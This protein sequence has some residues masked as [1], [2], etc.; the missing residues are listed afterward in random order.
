MNVHT[1]FLIRKGTSV[2]VAKDISSPPLALFRHVMKHDLTIPYPTDDEAEG[3][4]VIALS[5]DAMDIPEPKR[6]M[7]KMFMLTSAPGP[8]E[9]ASLLELLQLGFD[10]FVTDHETYP[11]MVVYFKNVD[12]VDETAMEYEPQ[13]HTE[14]LGDGLMVH[15]LKDEFRQ[16][17]A[18]FDGVH[19]PT[20]AKIKP[21][22]ETDVIE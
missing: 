7:L 22:T 5:R 13:W 1:T 12:E 18:S 17:L 6:M 14:D 8:K 21:F 16:A 15:R 4:K 2:W 11:L 10:V 20:K 3:P 9:Q 19:A